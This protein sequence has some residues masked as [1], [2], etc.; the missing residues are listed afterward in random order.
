MSL[1]ISPKLVCLDA[2]F[3]ALLSDNPDR[4]DA[5][6]GVDDSSVR[7][8]MGLGWLGFRLTDVVDLGVSGESDG[9]RVLEL[10]GFVFVSLLDKA[11]DDDRDRVPQ[12]RDDKGS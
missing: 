10:N 2:W 8:I 12:S 3:F 4:R 7:V 1:E 9:S 5:S 11:M 6:D